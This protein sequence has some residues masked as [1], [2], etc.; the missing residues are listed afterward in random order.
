MAGRGGEDDAAEVGG[1][2][3]G[4]VT[5]TG[6]T[7]LAGG[8][9]TIGA[10]VGGGA[11]GAGRA[12]AGVPGVAVEDGRVAGSETVIGD[13]VLAPSMPVSPIDSSARSS[14]VKGTVV[15]VSAR[16]VV[17][18]DV[19]G[20]VTGRSGAAVVADCRELSATVSRNESSGPVSGDTA[21]A[22][23]S[24]LPPKSSGTIASATAAAARATPTAINGRRQLSI[25]VPGSW[26]AAANSS[27]N[28]KTVDRALL[29]LSFSVR[30]DAVARVPP[31]A[32]IIFRR[33]SSQ[34]ERVLD[35]SASSKASSAG[36]GKWASTAAA[37]S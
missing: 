1:V 10:A 3:T 18:G 7:S 16:G 35:V 5:G 13:G 8:A 19:V 15:V 2:V 22:S 17:A 33:A 25:T 21:A 34:A 29:G 24:S 31:L 23:F 12:G 20:R 14:A 9:G 26:P 6:G 11:V 4:T 30:R 37:A 28:S 32:A 27:P 36:G